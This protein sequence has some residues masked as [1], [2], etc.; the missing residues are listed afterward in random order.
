MRRDSIFY[1]IFQQYPALL[2]TLL[3]NP[4]ENAWKYKFDSVAVKEPR[5]EIDGVFLPPD[6]ESPGTVYF[7]VSVSE[8]CPLGHSVPKA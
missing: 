1:K 3:T 5:F 4:P 2:F 8:A 6:E 7:C